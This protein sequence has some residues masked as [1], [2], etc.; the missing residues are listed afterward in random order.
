MKLLE[1]VD[2]ALGRA[3]GVLL[4]ALLSVMILL[5]FTQVILRNV[6]SESLLWGEIL[7]RH[8]VLWIGFFGAAR[9]TGEGRHI[10]IDALTRF[11]SPRLRILTRIFTNAFALTVCYFLLQA[12]VTFI[13]DEVEFGNTLH[14][15]IPSWYS[16]IIIPVG[17][18]L[19]MIHFFVRIV[20]GVKAFR[21]GEGGE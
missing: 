14:G 13:G 9:A 20:R 2:E 11:L 7:L 16:Q 21:T 3:E 5:S 1:R 4:I 17:F 19:M 10:N 12:S 8:L 18:G 6:F 15:N